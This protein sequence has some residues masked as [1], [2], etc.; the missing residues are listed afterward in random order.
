MA[1]V[2][3]IEQ[4]ELYREIRSFL[5]GL[6]PDAGPQ[7][8][9]GMQNNNPLP[10]N[11]VVMQV[12]F[13]SNLDETSIYHDPDEGLAHAQNSVEVRLQ[14]DFYG[15]LAEKR[16]RIVYNTW[17]SHYG[18][19]A[20]EL[21]KPLYVQSHTRH[22]YINDSNQ[23]EDRWIMDLALQYNP[24]VT[25]PQDYADETQLNINPVTGP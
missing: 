7:V 13:T 14:L 17:K 8:I 24:V 20:M 16:S 11:A 10:D 22:P 6:F 25:Y 12:L 23:Y 15:A 5:L 4:R 19:N 3:N 1:A 21:C 9:I 18:F 2:L